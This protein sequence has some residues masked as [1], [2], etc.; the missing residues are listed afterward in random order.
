MY[1]ARLMAL[2]TCGICCALSSK[3]A[4]PNEL[5]KLVVL[6]DMPNPTEDRLLAVDA[7]L[8]YRE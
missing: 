3:R 7:V 1:N 6:E 8:G 2:M 4:W 5:V